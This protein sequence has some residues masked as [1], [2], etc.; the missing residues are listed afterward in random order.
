MNSEKLARRKA[1]G[2]DPTA[3]T[4]SN[5][6]TP[7]APPPQ[8]LPYAEQGKGNMMNSPEVGKSMGG[9]MNSPGSMSGVNLY[10]YGD[11]GVPVT[12]GRMGAIG[13]APNSGKQQNHIPGRGLN[14][15]D[16]N[17]QQQPGAD[18]QMMMEPMFL[19]Q[20]AAERAKKLYSAGSNGDEQYIMPSY[21]VGPI[22]MMGTPMEQALN[23][24]NPG[25][26]P[27]TQTAQMPS[28]LGLQGTPD[29]QAA[30][31]MA[32]DDGSMIPGSTPQKIKKS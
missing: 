8:P 21:Q 24:P 4:K 25:Q 3:G 2:D 15:V 11:G 20:S 22:G 18:S 19:A 16:Y 1:A 29:A 26:I 32:P 12:D 17:M 9:G 10:P 6:T 27:P 23:R 31:A 7:G 30:A 5:Q 28:Q 14:Q 13:Y